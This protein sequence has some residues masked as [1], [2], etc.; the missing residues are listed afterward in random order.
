MGVGEMQDADVAEAAEV[1][2]VV[3]CRHADAWDG[4]D[5][6][7]GGEGAQERSAMHG[8]DQMSELRFSLPLTSDVRH[9]IN[10]ALE[11]AGERKRARIGKRQDLD[12]DR[13]GDAARGID[14]GG[15]R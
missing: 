8:G 3:V 11:P 14:P 4:A 7:R 13:A 10:A 12:H 9:L 15:A 6:G 2:N 5:R 1:V